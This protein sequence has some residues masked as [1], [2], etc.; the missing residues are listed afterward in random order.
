MSALTR[1]HLMEVWKQR[2][3]L[4]V[5]SLSSQLHQHSFSTTKAN[6]ATAS[7]SPIPS[8][9]SASRSSPRGPLQKTHEDVEAPELR[10]PLAV[11]SCGQRDKK[12]PQ[13]RETHV[14]W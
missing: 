6:M 14:F 13:Q 1:K 2:R 3:S 8:F 9:F 12:N 5:C 4:R 7:A 11:C 10:T